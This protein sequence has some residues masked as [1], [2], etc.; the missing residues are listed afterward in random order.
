MGETPEKMEIFG[1]DVTNLLLSIVG[2]KSLSREEIKD[3]LTKLDE[4]VGMRG[5]IR[6][7]EERVNTSIHI[8]Q[9]KGDKVLQ[10]K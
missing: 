8:L 1:Y 7:N 2:E 9:Y 6:F 3:R 4:Y 5:P 10:I